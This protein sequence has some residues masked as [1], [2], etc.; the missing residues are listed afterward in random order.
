MKRLILLRH[1]KSAWDQ[2][3]LDDKD[4]PLNE[5]GRH[6]A[7]RMGQWLAASGF[8]P[9]TVLCSTAVRTRETWALV[10]PALPKSPN[11]LFEDLLY[12]ASEDEMLSALRAADG[13]C[14]MMIGHMP[15]IGTLAADLRKKGP[16]LHGLFAKYP[17]CTAS[18][19]NFDIDDWSQV[20]HGSGTL[21]AFQVPKEL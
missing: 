20:K 7:P 19:I 6:D 21:L 17:T 4:R 10:A 14:V 5:R 12:L 18:V 8:V 15:G 9:D 1:A 13:D 2:T 11:I 3:S 16:M